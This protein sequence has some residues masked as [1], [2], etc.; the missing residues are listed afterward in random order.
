MS[1]EGQEPLVVGSREDAA[2]VLTQ[3]RFLA[4][5]SLLATLVLNS[6]LEIS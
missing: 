6:F 3:P 5:F 1:E 4:C 2:S